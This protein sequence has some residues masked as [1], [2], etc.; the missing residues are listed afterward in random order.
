MN[1]YHKVLVAPSESVMKNRL[2]RPLAAKPWWRHIR[3]A[4]KPR[5]LGNH[6]S[7]IKR[8][9]GSPSRSHYR[10]FRIHHE[11]S[12]EAPPGGEIMIT[13]YSIGNKTSSSR[14]PCIQIKSYYWTLSRSHGRSFR[15]RHE[16]VRVAPPGGGLM[17]TVGNKTPRYLGNLA[18]QIKSYYPYQEFMVALSESVMK[19]HIK[20][21]LE[22]KSRWHNNQFAVKPQKSCIAYKK[23]LL[24][25]FMKSWS[26]SNFYFK[27]NSIS[28]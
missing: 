21:P 28:L 14:K 25:T 15:I 16:K 2:K 1:H 5:H 17:M 4:I 11:K 3:L 20:R 7:Q 9:Y 27:K 10:S 12:R 8:Y 18:S 6:A 23:L 19:N 22:E 26:L 24:N 13:S